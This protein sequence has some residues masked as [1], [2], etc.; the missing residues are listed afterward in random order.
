ME[1]RSAPACCKTFNASNL[2]DQP[3]PCL[4]SAEVRLIW[5]LKALRSLVPLLDMMWRFCC[6]LAVFV[7]GAAC[8]A[9]GGEAGEVL[10]ARNGRN[11]LAAH[12]E[13]QA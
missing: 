12:T 7:L 8:P 10:C 13:H 1:R 4:V 9:A 3:L 6:V 2:D 11:Q 5:L